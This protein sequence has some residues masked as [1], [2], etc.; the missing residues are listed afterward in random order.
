MISALCTG[1]IHG[2][3]RQCTSGMGKPYVQATLRVPF[4]DAARIYVNVCA[5][6]TCAMAA[7]LALRDDDQCAIAGEWTPKV[8][9]DKGVSRPAA[10]I[11]AHRVLSAYVKLDETA[12]AGES[13]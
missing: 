4:G 5:F 13:A 9:F 12:T 2:E 10:D 7:L 6:S 1:V 3:P 11:V 8:F